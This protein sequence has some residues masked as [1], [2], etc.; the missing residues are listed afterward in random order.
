MANGIDTLRRAALVCGAL[1][2]LTL[3]SI[4]PASAAKWS[5]AQCVDAVRQQLGTYGVD[6]GRTRNLD[7]VGRCMRHG[8]G[9]ID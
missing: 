7:A 6:A 1:A 5:R 4:N 2:T 9:A 8:P 3:I